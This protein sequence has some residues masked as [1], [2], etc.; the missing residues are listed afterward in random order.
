LRLSYYIRATWSGIAVSW[1]DSSD[2]W[3]WE[4]SLF[5][6]RRELGKGHAAKRAVLRSFG[7][8]NGEE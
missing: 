8:N 1:N 3:Q 4:M 5:P 7:R 2:I 6:N